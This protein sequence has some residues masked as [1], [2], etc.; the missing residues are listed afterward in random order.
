MNSSTTA[1]T[2]TDLEP[3]TTYSILIEVATDTVRAAESTIIEITT[4][5][6]AVAK[7]RLTKPTIKKIEKKNGTFVVNYA[8]WK[9]DLV[10][11]ENDYLKKIYISLGSKTKA[12]KTL[13]LNP[14]T[15]QKKIKAKFTKRY[16]KNEKPLYV[17]MWAKYDTG[18]VT[19]KSKRVAVELF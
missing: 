2:I 18:E 13:K 3:N 9:E 5:S 8:D 19:T 1:Y 15:S 10:A 7:Q 6:K 14:T 11:G 17:R 4:E 12:T 16:R